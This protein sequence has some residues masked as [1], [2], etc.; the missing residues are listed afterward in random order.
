MKNLQKKYKRQD[1]L[2]TLS[3]KVISRRVRWGRWLIGGFCSTL[4]VLNAKNRYGLLL[5]CP[6]PK[7][8]LG[9]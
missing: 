2:K 3:K 7:R 4:K 8:P 5:L 9:L 6:F 1:N